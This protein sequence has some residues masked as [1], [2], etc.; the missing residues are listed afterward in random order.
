VMTRGTNLSQLDRR[1]L[2]S[3]L[4]QDKA[5]GVAR[6]LREAEITGSEVQLLCVEGARMWEEGMPENWFEH[7]RE[8]EQCMGGV[9]V[10]VNDLA[11]RPT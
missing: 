5:L 6:Q 9:L 7:L 2:E 10:M 4:A 3:W 11:P 1:E 8:C